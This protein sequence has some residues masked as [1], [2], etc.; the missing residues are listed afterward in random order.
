MFFAEFLH[1]ATPWSYVITPSHAQSVAI[2]YPKLCTKCLLTILPMCKGLS[3]MI[4][5]SSAGTIS[6]D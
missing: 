2:D 6:T 4:N 5:S 3:Y 1:T